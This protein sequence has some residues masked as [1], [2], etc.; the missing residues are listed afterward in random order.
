MAAEDIRL[1]L[2]R[3]RPGADYRWKGGAES[4]ASKVDWRDGVLIEPTQ[5][6]YDTEQLVLDTETTNKAT[7]TAA[8]RARVL[9]VVNREFSDLT[10]AEK[11]ACLE[12]LLNAAG[13]FKRNGDFRP[14]PQ[15]GIENETE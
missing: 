6:E 8:Q 12:R 4:D 7:L 5:A 11:D 13:A 3:L 10:T 9:P 2:E 15:W 14:L 1:L